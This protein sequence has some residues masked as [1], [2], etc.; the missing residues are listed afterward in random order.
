MTQENIKA[1]LEY[2]V[3]LKSDQKVV[4]EIDGKTFFDASKGNLKELEPIKYASSITVNSLTGLVGYIKSE[5]DDPNTEDIQEYLIHI[6]SPTKVTLLSKLNS[7]RQRE[8][9]IQS[10]AVLDKYPYGNFIDS[11]RFIINMLSL[12]DRTDDAEAIKRC[13]SS[14]RIEGGADLRDNGTS[15]Q[16]TVIQGA[17]AGTAEVPSPAM[18]K[19]FRTFLEV[20]QP[21]SQFIFRL[22]DQGECALFEADGGL[23]KYEATANILEYLQQE[24]Q[25]EI[26]SGAIKIIA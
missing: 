17:Q 15:Q 6:E 20:D 5:F 11:E 8:C 23:W 13:A 10:T 1:A 7:D 14:I 2:A 4:H 22:N 16:V 3:E 19:P 18:L 24:L 12:F 25:T 21:E 26:E 9:L